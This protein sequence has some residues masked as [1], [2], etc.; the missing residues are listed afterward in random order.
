M[1]FGQSDSEAAKQHITPNAFKSDADQ[2][3]EG[4]QQDV[5]H[6]TGNSSGAIT[7]AM[8]P[9]GEQSFGEQAQQK[10]NQAGSVFQPNDTKSIERQT[11]DYVTPGN[12]S[13]GA[14][15]ILNQMKN[16]VTGNEHK[17]TH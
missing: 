15:G 11:K 13:A 12:D 10:A 5:R 6:T 14:G 4:L 8:E 3:K 7:N 1:T 9:S 16:K 2:A 17:G